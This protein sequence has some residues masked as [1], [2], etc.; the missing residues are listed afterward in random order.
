LT[1]ATIP[2]V[3]VLEPH[4]FI[5]LQEYCADDL[6]VV[7]AARVSFAKYSEEMGDSER[8]LIRFLLTKR[9]TSPFEH[10]FFKFRVRAPII[11]AREWVR[12]R[13]GIA[14]NEESGR[15]VEL[16]PDAYVPLAEHIRTQTGKPGSYT[17][18]PMDSVEAEAARGAITKA[19]EVAFN[20][21]QYMLNLGVAKE[22]AR[23]VL[24]VGTYTEW[25]WSCNAHSLMHFLSL[26]AAPDAEQM[27]DMWGQ[28]MPVSH[29]WFLKTEANHA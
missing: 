3:T 18:E 29:E 10:T 19:Y 25:I 27:L 2:A 22:V 28:I 6:A 16:R 20:N 26:R 7:N 13:I 21:Y 24:P 15:Y 14:W 1:T 11:V 8:G 23:L 17:Y 9:H 5:E 4:G 12:H